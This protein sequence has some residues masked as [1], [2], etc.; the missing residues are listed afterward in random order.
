[1]MSLLKN[2]NL[3]K[4]CL[5]F[6][7]L[8]TVGMVSPA[9]SEAGIIPWTYNAIFGPSRNGPMF[10]GAGYAPQT[11]VSN[12]GGYGMSSGACCGTPNYVSYYGT[13]AQARRQSRAAYR[14]HLINNPQVVGVPYRGFAGNSYGYASVSYGPGCCSPCGLG[15]CSTGACGANCST[16]QCGVSYNPAT[17]S[18][19]TPD[20]ASASGSKV[21]QPREIRS[22]PPKTFAD[23]PMLP[24]KSKPG[25]EDSGFGTRRYDRSPMPKTE[26]KDAFEQPLKRPGK[27]PSNPDFGTEKPSFGPEKKSD[28]LFGTEEN[29]TDAF[30]PTPD[31]K[32][33]KTIIPK[34]KAA[35][36][37]KPSG[38]APKA[39]EATKFPPLRVRPLNLDQKITWKSA[40]KAERLTI[41]AH[42]T[43]PRVVKQ[44]VPANSGWFAITDSAKIASK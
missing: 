37:E 40:P 29:K 43:A 3:K 6:G 8:L 10:Y 25:V 2:M 15:G 36:I 18:S 44:N 34:K 31:G 42:F 12:Y 28:D 30:K 26:P 5:A 41:R 39:Q 32:L 1:M 7:C 21:P 16:G 17:A 38:T 14:W 35:P 9:E 33:P 11:Y 4:V 27:D 20:P 23:D 22:T 19:P 24:G 13:R